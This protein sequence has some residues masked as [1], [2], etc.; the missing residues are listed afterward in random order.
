M[1]APYKG[2]RVRLYTRVAP[3]VAAAAQT[4]ADRHGWTLSDW[5]AHAIAAQAER[6]RHHA[7]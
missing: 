2:L 1:A 7:T 5:I 3:A 6:E 4:A